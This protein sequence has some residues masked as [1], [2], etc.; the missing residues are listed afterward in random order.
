MSS[1]NANRR[2]LK[3]RSPLQVE[4][5]EDRSLLSSLSISDVTVVEG[6]AGP[7]SVNAVFTVTLTRTDALTVTVDA[8]S[9]DGTATSPSDYTAFPTT[10]LTFIN[11]GPLTQTVTVTVNGDT[12]DELDETFF[13]NLTNATNATITD[14][15]GLGT[16][17]DDD[18]TA[19]TLSVSPATL[20]ET[21]G[22]STV[23]ATLSAIS[24]QNVIVDLAYSGTATNLSDYTRSSTQIV[25]PAGSLTGTVTLTALPDL[26]NETNETIVVDIS[27]VTNGTEVVP[28]QVTE[29]GRAH[30]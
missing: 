3:R 19:V 23:T 20:A 7:G 13:V 5:L 24:G 22:T 11:G 21:G 28:Q 9:A 8:A 16:I 1:R 30:V 18:T 26:L 25:I 6:N 17:V 4:R 10:T 2:S 14:P 29:I 27:A 12:L 15:L